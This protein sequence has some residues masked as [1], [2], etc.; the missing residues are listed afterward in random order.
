[1]GAA[2]QE[3]RRVPLQGFEAL[4]MAQFEQTTF[5]AFGSAGDAGSASMVNQSM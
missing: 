1:M 2:K 4:A 3:L 5:G